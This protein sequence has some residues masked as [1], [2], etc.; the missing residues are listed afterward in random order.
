LIDV[1]FKNKRSVKL[2]TWS[3]EQEDWSVTM[4]GREENKQLEPFQ[5]AASM[6]F[7]DSRFMSGVVCVE[8]SV[9]QQHQ[10]GG[11]LG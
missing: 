2:L 4:I 9:V 10:A 6:V 3:G 8:Q 7:F 11:N 5:F 1:Y